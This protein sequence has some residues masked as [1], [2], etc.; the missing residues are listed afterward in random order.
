MLMITAA[1]PA[2]AMG[3]LGIGTLCYNWHAVTGWARR[4]FA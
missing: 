3:E 2:V 4:L 1:D